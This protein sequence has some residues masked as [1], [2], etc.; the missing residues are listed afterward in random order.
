MQIN[1]III[2]IIVIKALPLEWQWKI[3]HSPN[4]SLLSK[5]HCSRRGF[6]DQ[7]QFQVRDLPSGFPL[8]HGAV[9]NSGF[10]SSDLLSLSM[11]CTVCCRIVILSVIKYFVVEIFIEAPMQCCWQTWASMAVNFFFF[12]IIRRLKEK[13]TTN[14]FWSNSQ[15]P[16]EG[17]ER[18][19]QMS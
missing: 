12:C 4:Y 13:R 19:T 17:D 8:T 16:R 14:V 1:I 10:P 11:C 2:T 15:N 3:W 7:V 5:G 9:Y 18:H 6:K